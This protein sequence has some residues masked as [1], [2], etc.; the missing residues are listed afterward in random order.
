MEKTEQRSVDVF[1]I[2]NR[3]VRVFVYFRSM[4]IDKFEEK[5]LSLMVG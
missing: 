5:T 1:F 4:M 3:N 2:R